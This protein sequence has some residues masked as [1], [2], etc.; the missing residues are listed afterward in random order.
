MIFAMPGYSGYGASKFAPLLES[1]PAW[2][3]VAE[4]ERFVYVQLLKADNF[5]QMPVTVKQVRTFENGTG[6]AALVDVFSDSAHQNL[7]YQNLTVVT[8]GNDGLSSRLQPNW[9]TFLLGFFSVN[10][11][12]SRGDRIRSRKSESSTSTGRTRILCFRRAAS[13]GGFKFAALCRGG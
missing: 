9:S 1:V 12:E 10:L 7:V 11:E 6:V 8:A 13:E 5:Y 2:L 3:L 4:D